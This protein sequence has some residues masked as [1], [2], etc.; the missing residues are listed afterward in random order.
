MKRFIALALTLLMIVALVGC[1]SKKREPIELTLSTEDAEAILAAAGVR[2]PDAENA[3]GANSTVVWFGWSDPFQLYSEDDM[4][5][6]GFWTFKEKYNGKLQFDET[7]YQTHHDDLA[8]RISGG[9]PPDLIPG[10]SNATAIYPMNAIRGMIQ[11]IDPYIDYD[12]PLWA[13]MKGFADL[14]MLGSNHYQICITTKPSNVVVY[15]TRVIDEWG[16][17][18]PAEL[19]YNDEWTWDVFQDMCMDFSDPDED[20]YAL[21]GYAYVGFPMAST[22]QH[23]IY[24]DPVTGYS[25]NLDSPEIERA[26]NLLTELCRNECT[27]REG[28]N[29]WALRN[30]GTFGAGMKEGLCLFYVIGESFFEH[31]V[32]EVEAV[33]GAIS[34]GEIMFAPLP[35]DP[36]GDGVYYSESSFEDVKGACGIVNGA[37]NPEGAALLATCIRFRV[38]DPTVKAIDERN[39]RQIYLW[40]DAMIEMSKE[41]QEIA[42]RHPLVDP[43]GNLP[44]NLNNI[45]DRL[46]GNGIARNAS[47]TWAQLKE[48]NADSLDYYIQDLNAEIA[49]YN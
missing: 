8:M 41:C 45:A 36:M 16:F 30:S 29:L 3:P 2:L 43:I 40:N 47:S 44:T 10:G 37:S 35:R 32:E 24:H 17:A 5:N 27:Y 21:D 1:G 19:Y 28:S 23:V 11:P 20:R 42:D 34:E 25:S 39:K 13:P 6:T 9:T 38:V 22:G 33:W 7:T 15:N 4:P 31:S 26:M 18:D 14:F 12:D 48:E 46:C 49:S